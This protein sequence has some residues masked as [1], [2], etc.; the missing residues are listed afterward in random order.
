ME[1]SLQR[2]V[3]SRSYRIT[4]RRSHRYLPHFRSF[5]GIVLIKE[6]WPKL[7]KNAQARC[8]A[9]RKIRRYRN[10]P[11]AWGVGFDARIQWLGR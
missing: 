2:R 1:F 10:F 5:R 11:D 6:K 4:L 8:N 7:E 3:S 9:E